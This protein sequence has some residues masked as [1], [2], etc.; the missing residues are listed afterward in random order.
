[1][2]TLKLFTKDETG[3]LTLLDLNLPILRMTLTQAR[4]AS[5]VLR[6]VIRWNDRPLL[7]GLRDQILVFQV[8]DH[9]LFTGKLESDLVAIDAYC[10]EAVFQGVSPNLL[11]QTERLEKAEKID[12]L[13]YTPTQLENLDFILRDI[14]M[15]WWQSTDQEID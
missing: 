3:A 1:M 12:P 5:P 7:A 11:A 13:F 9:C 6:L 10:L 8:V 15:T 2:Q 14:G 4:G